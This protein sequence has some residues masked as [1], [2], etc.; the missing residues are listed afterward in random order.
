MLLVGVVC[1]LCACWFGLYL[2]GNPVHELILIL[3]S[4]IAPGFIV[5]TWEDSDETD[6][7]RT[8]WIHRVEYNY[9]LR[10][11]REFTQTTGDRTGRLRDD[12]RD[13]AQ[14]VP[15]EVEYD[16]RN[17][18]ISRIKG[19]GNA[20]VL[21]WLILR[22]GLGGALLA[23]FLSPGVRPTFDAITSLRRFSRIREGHSS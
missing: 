12:L 13:L 9:R 17:P 4:E 21:R 11:G 20:T 23:L 15:I 1:I 2:S 14:P 3:R 22:V 16:P 8:L 10:D 7:G 5:D 18:Q 19:D 6:D